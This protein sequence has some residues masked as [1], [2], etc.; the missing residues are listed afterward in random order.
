VEE[1]GAFA[2]AA[3]SSEASS[4][5]DHREA[6]LA[7]ELVFGVLRARPWLDALLASVSKR[8]LENIRPAILRI[9]RIGVYQ[10]AFLERVPPRAAVNEA[11]KQAKRFSNSKIAGFVNALLR[12]LSEKSIQELRPSDNDQGVS[13]SD[14]AIRHGLPEW[15][16]VRLVEVYGQERA[17]DMARAWNKP[18][19]RTLR[20]NVNHRSRENVLH[21]LGQV[22]HAGKLTPWSIDCEDWRAAEALVRDGLASHQD[23]GAQLIVLAADV[24]G[25]HRVLDACAGRGGKTAGLAMASTVEARIVAAD[26]S[27]AKLERLEFE[28]SRQGFEASTAAVDLT[29]DSTNLS[30]PFDRIV[31]DAPC[32]GTGTIGRRPEIRW[33]LTTA[34]VNSLV[35]VQKRLLDQTVRLLATKGRLIYAVCSVLPEE[36]HTHAKGFLECHPEMHLVPEAPALWP[37][38]IPWNEGQILIDPILS[39]TDG[40]QLLCFEKA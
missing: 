27:E 39:A 24:Q 4:L 32:S 11:V 30:G 29:Q 26:R 13:I 22:A 2:A 28:L 37:E 25:A 18:A 6:A 7:T 23:E 14:L 21:E 38:T 9:L 19:R 34:A 20:I 40:Y 35:G 16:L 17:L 5:K 31:L 3:L 8:P 36:G 33:R 1:E 10:I 12:R 15:L